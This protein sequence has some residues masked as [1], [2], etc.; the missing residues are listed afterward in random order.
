MV[1][2]LIASKEK[3]GKTA[4]CA[5]IGRKLL[6]QGK[7]V[8]YFS[9]VRLSENSN[10]NNCKDSSFIKEVLELEESPD[11]LSPVYLS[12]RE[13]WQSLTDNPED[14]VKKVKKNYASISKG[15]DVV[16]IE[17]LSGLATDNISTLAC[18]KIT[19][20]L[21][22]RVIILLRYAATLT[23]SDIAR[24]AEEL[25]RRLLGVVINFV[26]ESKIEILKPNITTA[27]QKAGIKILGLLPEARS[28][29]GISVKELA[30]ALGGEIFTSSE[31][32]GEIVENIMLGAMTPDSGIDYFSRKKDKA[33]VI[34]GERADM[35]LAALQTP[36][37]CLILT[38]NIKP[39]VTVI[40]EAESK[41]VPLIVVPKDTSGTVGD[42]EYALSN[43]AFNSPKKLKKFEEI[44][45][46]SL[47]FK[48]LY[49]A[50][51]L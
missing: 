10:A 34:R 40:S 48:S 41:H 15:K 30:E 20:A 7:K 37:K 1:N 51:G 9:P 50:L 31:D 21:D 42:I 29:L 13:L 49:S 24:V 36:T 16:I 8:G 14:F 35:Q 25:G 38:N 44:L 6:S 26:P 11:L 32:N 18:Y 12:S 19:E 4:L 23:P 17:G 33:T 47:D 28:L 27:F 46:T 5:G 43:R 2:L 3:A 45:D 22:A 39:L